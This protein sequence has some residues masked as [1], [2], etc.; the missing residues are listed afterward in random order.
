MELPNAAVL[1]L[2]QTVQDK[3]LKS[4]L[5]PER[6]RIGI[7]SSVK[8]EVR[9]TKIFQWALE[10]GLH[11]YFPRVEK[12]ILFYEVNGPD[13]LQRGSWSIPEPKKHCPILE[14][15][16]NLDVLII[17][18]IVFSKDCCR[19]GYGKGFYDAFIDT[20][21]GT[22]PIIALAYDFQVI[23][24]FPVD[25]WDRSVNAVVTEKKIYLREG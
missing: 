22:V 20:L 16:E 21:E 6:G 11:V 7:Y 2:S 14:E 4:S 19:V 9:T 1:S 18:G 12:G 25:A 3:F 10:K 5:C 23:D 17:P 13:D 24:S 15:D 8:N